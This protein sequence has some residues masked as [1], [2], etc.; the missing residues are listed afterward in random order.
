MEHFFAG[1]A[2][3]LYVENVRCREVKV[4]FDLTFR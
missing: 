1:L 2:V 3:E 4:T